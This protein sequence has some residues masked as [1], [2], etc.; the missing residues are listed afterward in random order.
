MEPNKQKQIIAALIV[1]VV[2]LAILSAYLWFRL[3]HCPVEM[4]LPSGIENYSYCV[5]R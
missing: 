4:Y 2:I 3:S 5:R 1:L